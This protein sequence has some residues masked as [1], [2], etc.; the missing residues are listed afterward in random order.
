MY[1]VHS[2]RHSVTGDL[3][4]LKACLTKLGDSCHETLA[5]MMNGGIER[6]ARATELGPKVRN[7]KKL[8]AADKQAA[9]DEMIKTL[10]REVETLSQGDVT[11]MK[12]L[13]RFQEHV[14]HAERAV[15]QLQATIQREILEDVAT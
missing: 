14:D 7:F 10:C 1:R 3:Q 8:D 13:Q 11:R 6:R 15:E 5:R 2:E 9:I 4:E 12:D